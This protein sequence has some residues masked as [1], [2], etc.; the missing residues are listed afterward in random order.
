[1]SLLI[2]FGFV[3]PPAVRAERVLTDTN[4]VS[5]FD[6]YGNGALWWRDDGQ[7]TG[8]F[9]HDSTIRIRAASVMTGTR[10]L[11]RDCTILPTEYDSAVRDDLYVYYFQ[12]RQLYRKA[13]S[14][15]ES[16]PG[17]VF[18]T[19]PHTPTL[20]TGQDGAYLEIAN[21]RL[22]FGRYRTDI[23][24]IDIFSIKTDGSESLQSVT[25][26]TGAGAHIRKMKWYTYAGAGGSGE[27]LAILLANGK[28]YRHHVT[29]GGGTVFLWV[30]I[31]DFSV[32]RRF[33]LPV[34]STYI[35]ASEGTIPGIGTLTSSTT[36][37][38]LYQINE[39]TGAI[40]SIYTANNRNQI[41]SVLAYGNSGGG[42]APTRIFLTEGVVACGALGCNFSSTIITAS[43]LG[44]GGSWGTIV[45]SGGGGNLRNDR[46]FLYYLTPT[47]IERIALDTPPIQ[48]DLQTLGLEAGH[49]IQNMAASVILPA[50]KDNLYVR[51]YAFARTNTT[52]QSPFFPGARLR[53]RV[54]GQEI[55]GSPFSPVNSAFI[56]ATN[57]LAVLRRALNRSF[58]FVLPALPAGSLTMTMTV[59]PNGALPENNYANNAVD[60]AQ[61]I[62]LRN[63]IGVC[64]R[65]YPM[66]TGMGTFN[67]NTPGFW[68]VITRA[69][70][71]LPAKFLT[72]ELQP[73]L[74][75]ETYFTRP[76]NFGAPDE[77]QDAEALDKIEC[78]R[79]QSSSEGASEFC[80]FRH[81]VGMIHPGVAGFG[82]LGNTPGNCLIATMRGA[83]GG[84]PNPNQPVGGRV[85]AHEMAHNYGRLHVNC[86]GP[87]NPDPNYPFNPCTIGSSDPTAFWG[88]DPLSLSIINPTNS[89]DLMS[90]AN[91]RWPSSWTWQAVLNGY[92]GLSSAS[93]G[94]EALSAPLLA[95]AG[96]GSRVLFVNGYIR[97][98]TTTA[99]FRTFYQLP[100][101]AV[102]AGNLARDFAESIQ[103]AD[104]PDPY[105][106]RLLDADEN[107]LGLTALPVD[108]LSDG[109]GRRLSF[110]HWVPFDPATRRVQLIQGN[111]V[112]AERIVSPRAPLLQV[113]PPVVDLVQQTVRLAWTASDPD[114]DALLFNVHYSADDGAS[115]NVVAN[116]YPG[117]AVTLDPRTLA[118]SPL[119]RLRVT[120]SDGVN[121]TA[122]VTPPFAL[123]KNPPQPFISGVTEGQRLSF[124]QSAQLFGAAIDPEQD[125]RSVLLNWSLTG[126]T[127]R[128][129][130]NATL[131]LHDLSPGAYTAT[132]TATDA[133][134]LS[135]QT[136]R[137]FEVLPLVIPESAAPNLDGYCRDRAY[138]NAVFVQ[139]PLGNGQ[140]A[141]AR[142]VHAVSN[143]YVSFTDL[144]SIGLGSVRRVGI[145]VD[146]NA[147]GDAAAQASDR[148]FFVDA[149]GIPAQEV[150][151]GANMTVTLSPLPGFTAVVG[152]GGSNAWSAE[153]RI[154]DSL[155]GGWNHAA[156][157]MLDHDAPHWPAAA[158]D[159]QPST[160]APAWFGVAPPQTNR[161]P[162]AHAGS[163]QIINL[164]GT[165]TVVLDGSAS[166]DPD[167]DAL[168]FQW[169]QVAGPSVTLSNATQPDA[170]FVIPAV[171]N[172]TALRF[173]LVVRDAQLP[174]PADEVDV[175]LWPTPRVE[176]AA[177]SSVVIVNGT[178][179]A[180]FLTPAPGQRFH[181]EATQD[182]A[183]WLK[184]QTNTAD[185][186]GIVDFLANDPAIYNKRFYRA[187]S[188]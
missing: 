81:W 62:S 53:V 143:L 38:H 148:G 116:N 76:F 80:K 42:S 85:L 19:P 132:L 153:L 144:Q 173:R 6:L 13:L 96:A 66:P 100:A 1:M 176:P 154:A 67:P 174:G 123:P 151:D 139:L 24:R 157:I 122:V 4:G 149:V 78:L 25:S 150:G 27:A 90:Y 131:L 61:P 124:G 130:T 97:P 7:C 22:W 182:F 113:G 73:P 16:D 175:T 91:N 52:G 17:T 77:T 168:T 56:D 15:A 26:I 106:I 71:L 83:G 181:I 46:D 89:G 21:G 136:A 36:A 140:F 39:D 12:N 152:V 9:P 60:L 74:G 29:G 31:T 172:T 159:H 57:D 112:L 125:S 41:L 185:A 69:D 2:L 30:R 87:D 142:L 8:E 14:A 55:D 120:A 93:A 47:T 10:S 18:A 133:D 160:W 92:T 75:G 45:F 177:C 94:A 63:S 162:V 184:V 161:P 102:D 155:L 115:W 104:M 135:D 70:S 37:G 33:T 3:S 119:A 167:G 88:L 32:H 186:F 43:P 48:F 117:L 128:A 44:I 108:H 111:V 40:A 51:G 166:H 105:F 98:Q 95:A 103:A 79:E 129:G 68:E 170:R 145:R 58:L 110:A 164:T 35:Y 11:A 137:R 99:V 147:S 146:A 163:D 127:P 188:Q 107:V 28:L 84:F 183:T 50:R 86:G 59:N 82:G 171:T 121:S 165:R 49:T 180:R 64:L 169:T 23:D 141:P 179:H 134:G 54:D 156:R 72:V 34:Q 101:T 158:N 114:G 126:P 187:V 138:T 20:F 109:P 65:M 118:G 178:L 5:G